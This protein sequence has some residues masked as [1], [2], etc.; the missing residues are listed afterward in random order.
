MKHERR[1]LLTILWG[2]LSMA[3]LAACAGSNMPFVFAP[4]ATETPPATSLPPAG[5]PSLTIAAPASPTSTPASAPPTMAASPSLPFT[6]TALYRSV[7]P[8]TYITDA[9]AYLRH[10]WD[11]AGSP[12][13]AIVVPVMYHGIGPRANRG[14]G[15][16]WTPTPY[17]LQTMEVAKQLGF[18]TVT[19]AQVAD[20]LE[21]NARIPARSLLLIVDDR[22]LGGVEGPLL[23]ILTAN[24]WTVTL[25]WIT[26][27]PGNRPDLWER[28]RR[29]QELGLVDIQAHGLHH[30]YMLPNTPE[31]EI[32]DEIWGPV[33][34]FEQEVGQRPIS[35]I[36]P[37]GNYTPTTTRIAR[38]AGYR[39]AFTVH[40]RGPLMYNWIP[41]G[42][43]ERAVNAP[44]MVL[45]RYWGYPGMIEQLNRAVAIAE[46]AR[47]HAL[48]S[49]PQEAAYYREHCGG[50]LPGLR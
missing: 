13:G 38:E 33:P 1:F 41:L 30:L 43:P 25:G 50:E 21:H 29:L 44:L 5:T 14:G 34:I 15:D 48:A 9:C 42:P 31:Q 11:P 16:T 8:T 26:G 12:P 17:F 22:R 10:R 40:S 36:W 37:G 46:E 28:L 39:L 45:P 20:F 49:Y 24:H 23:P 35:F 7:Q 18:E 6:T 19:A 47:Q 3:G 32:H 2:L 27:D 4:P